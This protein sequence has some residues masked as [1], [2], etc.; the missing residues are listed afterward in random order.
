MLSTPR[1]ASFTR[2]AD[3]TAYAANDVIC[4][5]TTVGKAMQLLPAGT[6]SGQRGLITRVVV[7]KSTNSVTNSAMS[8]ALFAGDPGVLA[9]NVS[10]AAIATYALVGSIYLGS[11]AVAT[12]AV[13]NGFGYSVSDNVL[14]TAVPFT[15]P[16]ALTGTLYGVLT[17]TA[18]W[19][20]AASEIFKVSVYVQPENL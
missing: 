16:T 1:E 9:D 5:S 19:T 18:A 13:P 10:F 20:P 12:F 7:Q 4:D 6:F 14:T 2:P 3:T 15:H 8:L 11:I 17:A